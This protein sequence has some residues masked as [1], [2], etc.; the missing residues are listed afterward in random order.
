MGHFVDGEWIEGWY[1]N[2]KGGKFERP[3]T[4]FRGEIEELESDRYHLYAAWACPWAHRVLLARSLLGLEETIP[5]SFVDWFLDDGGWRFYPEHDGSTVDHLYGMERL[6]ELYKRA[7]DDYTGRV[8]VPV[9][10]DR[11]EETIVNNESR[12]ILRNLTTKLKPWHNPGAPDLCPDGLADEIDKRLDEI[13]EP[14]NNGVYKAGFATTQAAYD[15]AVGTL[16]TELDRWD[17]YLADHDYL[18]GDQLTEADICLFTSMVRFDPVYHT[19]FK[20]SKKMI[21]EYKNLSAH[22]ERMLATPGVKRT[23]HLEQIVDHYYRS[24]TNINPYGI[25]AT[26]PEGAALRESPQKVDIR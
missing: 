15:D 17:E 6:R 13:Y 9:L 14:I 25:V 2:D 26:L 4:T 22:L 1:S 19:H 5:V 12:L 7:E 3:P 11:K 23:C 24:H 16:F 10:W 8:T 20:C 18:V 21:S